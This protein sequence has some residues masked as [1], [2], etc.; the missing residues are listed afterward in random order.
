MS[1]TISPTNH[2]MIKQLVELRTEQLCESFSWIDVWP[3]T[4]HG[5]CVMR[6]NHSGKSWF[7]RELRSQPLDRCVIGCDVLMTR[8]TLSHDPVIFRGDRCA[9]FAQI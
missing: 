3:Q 6:E 7:L 1:S 4:S 2:R 8:A 9:F 5:G